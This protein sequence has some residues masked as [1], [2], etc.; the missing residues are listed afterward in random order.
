MNGK[1]EALR[2]EVLAL[3]E[4]ERAWLT[5]DLLD[6]LD[7]RPLDG[8]EA[9]LDRVWADE[10]ARRAAQI[11]SGDVLTQSWDDVMAQVVE[12]RSGR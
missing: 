5:I 4:G 11:D 9:E 3:S 7:G 1:A 6:S 8:D 10:T 2:A 12:S